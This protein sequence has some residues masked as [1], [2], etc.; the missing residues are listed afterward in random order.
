M[1]SF[2]R[3]G[4]PVKLTDNVMDRYNKAL[5]LL[6]VSEYN[7]K[8]IKPFVVFGFDMWSAGSTQSKFGGLLGIPL[9][10]QYVDGHPI[11]KHDIM[12]IT[13][14]YHLFQMMYVV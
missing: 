13:L 8:L 12:V 10:F 2:F 5:E 11:E 4:L 14:P 1:S 3:H 6:N 9:N 7:R